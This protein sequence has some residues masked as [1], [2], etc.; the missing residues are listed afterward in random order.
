MIV[1]S[2]SQECKRHGIGYKRW[3]WLADRGEGGGVDVDDK[4]SLPVVPVVVVVVVV[5]VLPSWWKVVNVQS[6]LP[7][8]MTDVCCRNIHPRQRHGRTDGTGMEEWFRCLP[9]TIPCGGR[10]RESEREWGRSTGDPVLQIERYW[11]LRGTPHTNRGIYY[12]ICRYACLMY[13]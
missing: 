10:T 8:K 4:M 11:V 3:C 1:Q 13:F 6:I 7:A 5:V 12:Q 9:R 2:T